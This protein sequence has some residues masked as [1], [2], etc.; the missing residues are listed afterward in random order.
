MK[1]LGFNDGIGVLIMR[2]SKAIDKTGTLDMTN[3]HGLT[4]SQWR[5]IVALSVKEGM[6]QKEIA[7]MIFLESPTLVTAIDKMEKNDLVERRAD[8]K[9]RRNNK[10]FLTKKSK[11]LIEP[12][13]DFILDFRKLVTKNVSAKD[14]EICKEVL[15]KITINA[16]TRYDE[17]TKK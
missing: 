17:I 12:V 3:Q 8:P 10:I 2:A 4:G 13:V 5:V 6:N 1:D 14:L 15:R 7:E 16:N 9:D 11:L